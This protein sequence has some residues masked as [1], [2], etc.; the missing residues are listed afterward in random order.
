MDWWANSL[1][2]FISMRIVYLPNGSFGVEINGQRQ[3]DRDGRNFTSYSSPFV[4]RDDGKLCAAFSE[5]F[6]GTLV[7][8]VYELDLKSTTAVDKTLL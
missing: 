6:A 3:R 2:L 5:Y 7:P 8:G 4:F 1:T